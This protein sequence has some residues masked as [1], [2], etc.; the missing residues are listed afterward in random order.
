MIIRIDKY[1]ADMGIGT[2]SQVKEYIKAGRVSICAA[3]DQN[4]SVIRDSAFKFDTD[5]YSIVFDGVKRGYAEKEYFILNKPAGYVSSTRD[6][7]P[8]VIDLIKDK[9]RKDLFPVGRLDKDTEGF[10][11]ISNDGDLAHRMLSPGKHVSKKYFAKVDGRLRNEHILRFANGILDDCLLP[12]KL[13]IISARDDESSCY[14]TIAEG[15]YHQIKRMMNEIGLNVTYLKRL[16]MGGMTLPEGLSTGEY[17]RTDLATIEKALE[18]EKEHNIRGAA[19]MI[20]DS[21]KGVIFDVDGT[22]LDS[23]GLWRSID[24][25]FLGSRGFTVPDDLK[26]NIEG[27]NYYETACYFKKAFSLPESIDEIMKIWNDMA[28]YKYTHE[29]ELKEGARELIYALKE[30]GIKLGIGTS[31]ARALAIPCL[32]SHNIDGLFDSIMTGDDVTSGKPSP[33]IYLKCAEQMGVPPDECLVFEDY[34]NGVSAG[35]AAGMKTCA[36]HDDN[37]LFQDEEK[38]IMADYYIKSFMEVII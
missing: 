14:I 17:I 24:E 21:V 9:M 32:K 19:P 26:S 4:A 30:K 27:M 12:A 13:Q 11:L 37:S 15:K 7:S 2:R 22:L 33:D 10:M 34:L 6:S 31:N 1:M 29:V 5:K 18:G 28:L 35:L 20:D 25:E 23:M 36:V 38:Q 8:T 3:D 16:S